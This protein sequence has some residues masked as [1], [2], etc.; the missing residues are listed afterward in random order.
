MTLDASTRST[1]AATTVIP[2]VVCPDVSRADGLADALVA[3]GL[4]VAEVTFR[5][6]GAHTVVSAIADRDDL[7]VGA[8]TIVTA[9]QAEQAIK[10]GARFIISPGL[11]E[12]VVATCRAA[13][14]PVIPGIATATELLHALDL[15]LDTVK[16]FPAKTS[17]GPAAI[18]ALAAPFGTV[19]FMPTGGISPA[20]LAD[21]LAITQVLAVG[22]SWMVDARALADGD[23]A[24]I[25]QACR[26]ARELADSIRPRV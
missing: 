4:P 22:G 9:A 11:S 3:G 7:L 5:T 15:G 23:F 2:V 18:K 17:G 1:L 25:R 8:G 20:N 24:A 16:F 19:S 26:A 6:P 12:P 21:Y 10:A 14:V 13:G